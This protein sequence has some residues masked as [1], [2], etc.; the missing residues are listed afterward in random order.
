SDLVVAQEYV[1]TR[2]DWRVGV[3]DRQPLFACRYHMAKDHW[4]IIKRDKAGRRS[5]GR[6]EDVPLDEAPRAVVETAGNAANLIGEGL[7]RVDL[8]EIGGRACIIEINDNPNIDAGHE[9]QVLQ[10]E[11]YRRIVGGFANRIER[12]RNEP[13]V[14]AG[15]PG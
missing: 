12:S 1:P 14:P 8:K 3:W 11:L 13:A 10:E 4:Q 6:V 9:D 7:S 5:E 15:Q 2:F